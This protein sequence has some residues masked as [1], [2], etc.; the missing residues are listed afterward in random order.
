M[1]NILKKV[2]GVFSWIFFIYDVKTLF[3]SFTI[4]L[5][6]IFFLMLGIHNYL[7]FWGVLSAFACMYLGGANILMIQQLGKSH[8]E[9]EEIENLIQST[10]ENHEQQETNSESI[11]DAG[12]QP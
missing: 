8:K 5:V 4:H 1:K 9:K 12:I 3:L 11:S 2:F 10:E 7:G 6:L